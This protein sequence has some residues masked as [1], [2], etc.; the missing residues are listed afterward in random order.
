MH[1]PVLS[2]GR[3]LGFRDDINGLR[4]LAVALVMLYHFQ[5]PGVTGGF[6][7]VDV[8]FVVSGYLMTAIIV[9]RHEAGKFSFLGFYLARARRIVPALAALC[10]VLLAFGWV[11]LDAT[12]YRALGSQAASALLF[13]SNIVFANEVGYFDVDAHEK[14]LLHTWS[15]SVEWQ[16]YLLY[17][18]VIYAVMRFAPRALRFVLSALLVA[19]LALNVGLG[20]ARSSDAFYLLP[21]RAWE[22]LA[23]G[24]VFVFQPQMKAWRLPGAALEVAGFAL[25]VLGAVNPKWP[26]WPTPLVLPVIGTVLVLIAARQGS[27]L[28]ANPVSRAIGQWSYSIYLWHWPL[29]VAAVYFG[30]GKGAALPV[31]LVAASILFG[32]VSYRFVEE[33]FRHGTMRERAGLGTMAALALAVALPAGLL[34]LADGVPQRHPEA[35]HK[36][37]RQALT[38][39]EESGWLFGRER[40]GWNKAERQPVPC[41]LG[42][43]KAAPSVAVWGDSHASK[44]R[45]ALEAALAGRGMSGELYFRNGCRPLQGLLT[46]KRGALKDCTIYNRKVLDRLA[47]DKSVDTLIVI[48][49]WSYDVGAGKMPEGRLKTHF[50][51]GPLPTSQERYAEYGAHMVDDLCALKRMKAHVAVTAPL[52]YFGIDVPKVM[53]RAF[54]F[55]GRS[56]VPMLSRAEHVAR[57]KVILDALAKAGS[58]CGVEVLDPLPAL[59]DA[60]TCFAAEDGSPVFSDDNHLSEHGNALV[61]PM[62]D[63]FLAGAR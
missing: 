26:T 43:Q 50:G 54:M 55:A 53:S 5:V 51:D 57:N 16:F 62:L 30:V 41:R 19:S 24:L 27:V 21:P 11:W 25:I 34:V 22:L 9:G 47:A 29:V 20:G 28:T 40:C 59:C 17:P 63:R 10:A 31:L 32:A 8:F 49:N 4:A 52:P 44:Y 35:L 60:T 46:D 38:R 23:G 58:Q 1:T 3:S 39:A 61:R 36:I 33:P 48:A 6:V 12:D 2:A 37:E 15:L 18:V 13:F 56:E 45:S 7:G 14:W 42:D